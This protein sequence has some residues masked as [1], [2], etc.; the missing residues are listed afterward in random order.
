M[1]WPLGCQWH[2]LSALPNRLAEPRPK[3]AVTIEVRLIALFKKPEPKILLPR[4]VH[5]ARLESAPQRQS[6]RLRH[7]IWDANPGIPRI[8]LH[9]YIALHLKLE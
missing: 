4:A 5:V 1:H 7:R 9:P 6:P 3:G 2:K 8:A